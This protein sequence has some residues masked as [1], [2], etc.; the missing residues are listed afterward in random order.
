MILYKD[1]RLV[2]QII[3]M[4]QADQVNEIEKIFAEGKRAL[5]SLHYQKMELINHFKAAKDAKE[6]E[7]ILEKIRELQ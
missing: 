6:A 5:L 3:Y 1:D 4:Q 2:K 7:D